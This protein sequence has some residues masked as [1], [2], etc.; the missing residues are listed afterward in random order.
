MTCYITR[1]G[2]FLPGKAVEND[3]IPAYLG[4]MEGDAEVMAQV[5]AMNGIVRRHY[6]QDL[7]QQATHDVYELAREAVRACLGDASAEPAPSLL[8]CG[9]TYGPLAAPGFASI[10]H[11][12]LQETGLITRP[13][14]VSSHAGICSSGAAAM[15]SAVRAIASG[16]HS[17][18]LC[19]AAEHPSEI[20]KASAIRPVDDRAQHRRLRD[21]QWFMSMFLRYMLSDGAGA[22]LLCD[23]PAETGISLRV[24]WTNS[25][26][27]AN[28]APLCMKLDN[29]QRLLTQ[30]LSI[31]S[32]HLI[33]LSDLFLRDCLDSH[34][35]SL[36]AYTMIL[37]HVSSFFFRSKMER[38]IARHS[39]DESAPTPY[40]TNLATAGNTGAASIY[41]M[42]DHYLREHSLTPGDRLLLFI[43]ESGRFNFVAVSLTAVAP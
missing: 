41:V 33:P 31:L 26:S 20:L 37:P 4:S 5:L 11:G 9:A 32:R 15:V 43:P 17:R 42:L 24:D 10:L 28:Q 30:D 29:R 40:W 14:E 3:A 21:S 1:T 35:E 6:A 2:S 16:D 39:A 18:A 36:S 12:A 38:I 19:V 27:Y 13:L 7:Q 23:R 22:M 8:S 34:D 25:R